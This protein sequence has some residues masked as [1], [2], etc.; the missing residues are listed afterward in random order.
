MG[1]CLAN[2]GKEY[3][4]Y[5]HQSTPFKLTLSGIVKP[6]KAKWFQPFSGKYL[7]AG[8]LDNGTMELTPPASLGAGPIVLHIDQ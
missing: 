7:N 4:V 3:I 6:L 1:Y 5:Q 8:R 2:P